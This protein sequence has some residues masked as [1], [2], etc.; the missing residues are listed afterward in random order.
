MSLNST[1][2]VISPT[3]L[4][5]TEVAAWERL[6]STV[7]A[8]SSPFL[9]YSFARAVSKVR[10]DVHVA[11]ISGADGPVA[12]FPFQ[13]RD[14]VHKALRLA[15]PAGEYM[16]GY[17]GLVAEPGYHVDTKMLLKLCG[18]C[19]M[20][21]TYLEERQL[22]YGLEASDAEQG[23][24]IRLLEG[25]EKFWE[26]LR[27][28]DKKLVSE[29][30]RRERQLTDHYGPL[31]FCFAERGWRDPMDR[32]IRLKQ[33]QYLRTDRTNQFATQWKRAL[34]S[35][36]AGCSSP[37]CTG[38]LST[39]HAGDTWVASHF[40]LRNGT[41][42]NYYFPVYNRELTRYSPGHLLLKMII[43][44]AA[45]QGLELIDRCAGNSQAKRDFANASHLI[46]RAAWYRPGLRSLLYRCGCSAR[47][48]AGS[49][50]QRCAGGLGRA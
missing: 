48:R 41:T 20:R 2:R 17:M 29:V 49:L 11:V 13:F 1:V 21:V 42:L 3:A 45:E 30:L 44:C 15:E 27:A 23:F 39:L 35:E 32:L 24:L 22:A 40:G 37:T 16:A 4:D 25:G 8:L 12:F 9:S 43:D 34:L 18:V 46:Y 7:P 50:V 31:R 10:P 6:S 38:V 26:E 19:Y 47:W 36:L 14:A 5:A 33:E 28:R